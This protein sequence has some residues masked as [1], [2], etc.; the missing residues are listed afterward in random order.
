MLIQIIT[1]RTGLLIWLNQLKLQGAH[2]KKASLARA[3]VA[4]PLYRV[5][6][7]S[8]VSVTI[9]SGFSSPKTPHKP[10]LPFQHHS[11]KFQSA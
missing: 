3:T 7:L 9:I 10:C 11:P 8:S 5:C 2:I 1:P 6:A 4:S